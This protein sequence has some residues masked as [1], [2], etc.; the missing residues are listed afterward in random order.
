VLVLGGGIAGLSAAKELDNNGVSDFLVLESQHRI[1]GRVHAFQFGEAPQVTMEMGANWIQGAGNAA[2]PNPLSTWAAARGLAGVR[3]PG[4]E[5]N[6]TGLPIYAAVGGRLLNSTA[7]ATNLTQDVPDCLDYW[8]RKLPADPQVSI[9]EVLRDRCYWEAAGAMDEALEWK[10]FDSDFATP[11]DQASL[12]N[13]LP[14]GNYV[15]FGP[16][17][18]LV[19][20]QRQ[21]GFAGFLHTNNNSDVFIA[22]HDP[23][24]RLADAVVRIEYSNNHAVVTTASGRRVAADHVLTTFSLGVLQRGVA[25]APEAAAAAGWRGGGLFDP[26]MP[27]AQRAA[28]QRYRMAN[29]TKVHLQ[30]PDGGVFWPEGPRGVPGFM[31]AGARGDFASWHDYNHRDV[32]PGSRTLMAVLTGAQAVEAEARTDAQVAAQAMAALRGAFGAGAPEPT[33]VHVTR[34]GQDPHTLGAYS[35][36]SL[37]TADSDYA[38]WG[39]PLAG[40]VFFAGEAKCPAFR[41]YIQGAHFSGRTTAREILAARAALGLGN[42][43]HDATPPLYDCELQVQ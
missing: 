16:D 6:L 7:R 40:R 31:I 23:R 34:W 27:A 32:L 12:Q 21:T 42:L 17:D 26:P 39:R 10:A 24:I 41:G 43:P 19:T 20:D 38:L 28:L 9:A 4:S 8:A 15:T 18:V 1:G 14:D 29:F 11:P 37:A 30:F 3:I 25:A 33:A 22:A 36:S 35:T 2:V 5:Q 13:T